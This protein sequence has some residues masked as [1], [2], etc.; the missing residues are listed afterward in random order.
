MLEKT[1][2]FKKESGCTDSLYGEKGKCVLNIVPKN[3]KTKT[4]NI[5]SKC[6]PKRGKKSKN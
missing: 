6:K 3:K 4:F 2:K 5:D 1:F